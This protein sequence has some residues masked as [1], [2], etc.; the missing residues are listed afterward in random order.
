MGESVAIVGSRDWPEPDAVRD[1]VNSLSI[2]DTVIS[3]GARGVDTIAEIA[4]IER[5]LAFVKYPPRYDLYGKS[6]TFIRNKE[7]VVHADR[8]VAFHFQ[9]SK[10]TALTIQLARDLK[11]PV[12]VFDKGGE[13]DGFIRAV[14]KP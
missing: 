5:G 7:I 2:D 9:H 10:G 4:A 3:G 6:A 11:K 14:E 1:Y 8:V 13:L 12:L